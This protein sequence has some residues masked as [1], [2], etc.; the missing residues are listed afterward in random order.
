VNQKNQETVQAPKQTGAVAN[1]FEIAITP[2]IALW[3]QE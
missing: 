3:L 1:E 2:T